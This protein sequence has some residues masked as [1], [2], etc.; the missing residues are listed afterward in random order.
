MVDCRGR[1]FVNSDGTLFDVASELGEAVDVVAT[2]LRA[3]LVV[4]GRRTMIE[5]MV[6]TAGL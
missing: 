4:V 1:G 6:A 5:N 2:K 3:K